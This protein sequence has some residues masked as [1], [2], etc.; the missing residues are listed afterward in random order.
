MAEHRQDPL[1][2]S[3]VGGDGVFVALELILGREREVS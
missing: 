2:V 1:T 3:I